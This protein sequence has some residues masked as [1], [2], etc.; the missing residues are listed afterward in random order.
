[1]NAKLMLIVLLAASAAHCFELE[2]R[3]GAS[4]KMKEVL[5]REPESLKG[6]SDPAYVALAENAQIVEIFDDYVNY[7]TEYVDRPSV[8]SKELTEFAEASVGLSFADVKIVSTSD[9]ATKKATVDFYASGA[10]CYFF[11][12][13][14]F[15][16]VGFRLSTDLPEIEAEKYDDEVIAAS[17][18]SSTW[19]SKIDKNLG[20]KAAVVIPKM[21]S[22]E[23]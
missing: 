16:K 17:V 6:K 3:T 20:A 7:S 12:P 4:E 19:M 21:T 5:D 2:C 13:C 14:I 23:E 15:I 9:K 18:R 11:T 1:M 22:Q 10:C 8:A